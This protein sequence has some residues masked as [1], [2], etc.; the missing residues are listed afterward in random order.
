MPQWL[1]TS[2]SDWLFFQYRV[3]DVS[4]L[5]PDP[6]ALKQWMYNL[7]YEKEATLQSV[8]WLVT[9][10]S[11]ETKLAL[12]VLIGVQGGGFAIKRTLKFN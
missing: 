9:L 12:F 4:D 11:M 8:V 3:F 6:E 1:S 2:K 7:Y 5:P 10:F